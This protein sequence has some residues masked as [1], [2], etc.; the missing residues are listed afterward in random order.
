MAGKEATVF[1]VDLGRSMG[2]RRHGRNH[3]DLEWAMDYVWDK[4]T[5]T[6]SRRSFGD[7]VCISVLGTVK[8]L[9]WKEKV[10]IESCRLRLAGKAL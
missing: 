2:E 8:E 4:I 10:D 3:T 5:T 7:L 1:I 9:N 6:V